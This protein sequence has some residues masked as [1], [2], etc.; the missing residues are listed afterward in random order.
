MVRCCE[1]GD[2]SSCCSFHF[3][4]MCTRRRLVGGT[5]VSGKLIGLNFKR[6]CCLIFGDGAETL[7]ANCRHTPRFFAA[8]GTPEVHR[9][10][11][12]KSLKFGSLQSSGLMYQLNDCQRLKQN[13]AVQSQF[14]CCKL[15]N[16]SFPLY[17]A[18]YIDPCLVT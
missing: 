3:S 12:L 2:V 18:N 14:L 4:G 11:R 15:H 17:Y 9:G 5:D 16:S 6:I 8:E 1:D 7:E 10:G 13:S